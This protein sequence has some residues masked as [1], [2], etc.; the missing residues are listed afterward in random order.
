M[1]ASLDPRPLA[2]WHAGG[3][4]CGRG[5]MVLERDDG[6]ALLELYEDERQAALRAGDISEAIR[7]SLLG[8]D[9]YWAMWE[10]DRWMRA[11]QGAS[12]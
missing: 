8:H 3:S 6:T 2:F 4:L 7:A 10:Q 9:L 1:S 12:R 11:A 5:D